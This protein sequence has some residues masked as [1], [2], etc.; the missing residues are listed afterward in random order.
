MMFAII[1]GR[2]GVIQLPTVNEHH[3]MIMIVMH[4]IWE[5]L[6]GRAHQETGV[7]TDE[8]PISIVP[9]FIEEKSMLAASVLNGLV[10]RTTRVFDGSSWTDAA[11]ESHQ[12]HCEEQN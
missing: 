3:F 8:I 5:V 10:D 6:P 11:F 7:F 4:D 2:V 12:A 9:S 1:I